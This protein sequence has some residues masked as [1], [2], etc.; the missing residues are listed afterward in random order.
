[1]IEP[2]KIIPV[3]PA[4]E[5]PCDIKYITVSCHKYDN[6]TLYWGSDS[7]KTIESAQREAEYCIPGTLRIFE[8]PQ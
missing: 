8:V 6:G 5:V 4:R 7:H 2:L 1:M 3:Q